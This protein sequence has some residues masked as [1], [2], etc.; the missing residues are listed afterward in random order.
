MDYYKT[1]PAYYLKALKAVLRKANPSS[2]VQIPLPEFREQHGEEAAKP[3]AAA[4]PVAALAPALKARLDHLKLEHLK[5]EKS[6]VLLQRL[7]SPRPQST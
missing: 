3:S 7:T 1:V 5:L 4:L 2:S 6:K